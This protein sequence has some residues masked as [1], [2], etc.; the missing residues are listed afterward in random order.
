M[1][2]ET[3]KRPTAPVNLGHLARQG[4]GFDL[5]RFRREDL[6]LGADEALEKR[7]KSPGV[8]SIVTSLYLRAHV[9]GPTTLPALAGRAR[10]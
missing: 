1:A 7:W 8:G 6:V 5:H 10:S 2:A 9:A 3:L 4:L